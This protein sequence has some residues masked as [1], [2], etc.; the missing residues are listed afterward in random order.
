[1]RSWLDLVPVATAALTA[2]FGARATAVAAVAVPAAA[3]GLLSD[4]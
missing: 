3:P 1:M 2:E 4:R